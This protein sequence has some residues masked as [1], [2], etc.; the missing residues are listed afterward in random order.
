MTDGARAYNGSILLLVG[1][2][3]IVMAAI[4][5]IIVPNVKEPGTYHYV[6]AAYGVCLVVFLITSLVNFAYNDL[7]L[8]PTLLQILFTAL[9]VMG[10]PL[11][12][13]GVVLLVMKRKR[14]E[15]QP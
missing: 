2:I 15:F 4:W 8:V 5:F 9:M 13:W 7:L 3:A 14:S 10:I 6:I 12:V 1:L 11:A